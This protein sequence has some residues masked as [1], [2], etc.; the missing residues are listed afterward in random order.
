MFTPYKS[1]KRYEV[2]EETRRN[3]KCLPENGEPEKEE[4]AIHD[5]QLKK[6]NEALQKK[7]SSQECAMVYLNNTINHL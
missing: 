5:E 6:S 2:D 4:Q 7:L 1:W 3:K